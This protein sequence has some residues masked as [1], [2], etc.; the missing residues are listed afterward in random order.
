MT[1]LQKQELGYSKENIQTSN[2]NSLETETDLFYWYDLPRSANQK[3]EAFVS[4]LQMELL[5]NDSISMD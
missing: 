4:V 2:M 3:P 5:E 1:A